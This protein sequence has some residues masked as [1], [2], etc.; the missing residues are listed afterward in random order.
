MI[1][2]DYDDICKGK[3]TSACFFSKLSSATEYKLNISNIN[4]LNLILKKQLADEQYLHINKWRICGFFFVFVKISE[5]YF[6]RFLVLCIRIV[7]YFLYYSQI[8]TTTEYSY[9]YKVINTPEGDQHGHQVTINGQNTRRGN[10]YVK[11]A[12]G[13]DQDVQYY[14]DSRG[15]QPQVRYITQNINYQSNADLLQPDIATKI[16]V[17]TSAPVR[18]N[19]LYILVLF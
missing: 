17:Y 2:E 14:A 13:S 18:V 3:F 5:F 16:A 1:P 10:Y 6:C 11:F 9:G 7:I 8:T 4:K 15:Y 12:D 19:I